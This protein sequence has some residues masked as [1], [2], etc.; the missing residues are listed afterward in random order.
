MFITE[1]TERDDEDGEQKVE[2]QLMCPCSNDSDWFLTNLFY[3]KHSRVDSVQYIFCMYKQRLSTPSDN[4]R[5][6][7]ACCSSATDL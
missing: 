4:N 1:E 7:L 6:A 2:E 3:P 5:L